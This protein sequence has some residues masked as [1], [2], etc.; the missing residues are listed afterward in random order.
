MKVTRILLS[1]GRGVKVEETG[2]GVVDKSEFSLRRNPRYCSLSGPGGPGGL[3]RAIAERSRTEGHSWG[4][5][6]FSTG[7]HKLMGLRTASPPI[8][9]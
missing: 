3:R 2:R 4:L 9:S 7:F 1:P 6:D 5:D 8:W